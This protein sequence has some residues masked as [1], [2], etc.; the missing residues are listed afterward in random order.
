[1]PHVLSKNS[2]YDLRKDLQPDQG[3]KYINSTVLCTEKGIATNFCFKLNINAALGLCFTDMASYHKPDICG[4]EK[5]YSTAKLV[6]HSIHWT[7]CGWKEHNE[8]N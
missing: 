6:F 5:P 8:N 2:Q 3:H 1:M 7:L 4:K